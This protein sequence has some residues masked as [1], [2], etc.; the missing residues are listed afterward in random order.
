MQKQCSIKSF[1][2]FP[3]ISV[4]YLQQIFSL[5]KQLRKVAKYPW[6]WL[7]RVPFAQPSVTGVAQVTL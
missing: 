7:K 4:T 1:S 3:S 2:I 6:Y 5:D